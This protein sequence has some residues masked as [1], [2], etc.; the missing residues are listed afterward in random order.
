VVGEEPVGEVVGLEL[1]FVA[2]GGDGQLG[3]HYAGVIDKAV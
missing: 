2:V 3:G 1:G